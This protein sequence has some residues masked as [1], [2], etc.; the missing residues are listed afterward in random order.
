MAQQ[1]RVDGALL[2]AQ[3]ETRGENIFKLHPEVFGVQFLGFHGRILEKRKQMRKAQTKV[4]EANS[5]TAATVDTR[6]GWQL[7]AGSQQ[8]T[9]E[10]TRKTQHREH[11]GQSTEM[12]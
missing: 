4:T 11:R 2:D 10:R 12:T 8:P 7:A 9:V 3:A 1:I 5:S 6:H